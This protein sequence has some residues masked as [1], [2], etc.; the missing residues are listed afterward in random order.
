MGGL[1]KAAGAQPGQGR[2]CTVLMLHSGPV[3]ALLAQHSPALHGSVVEKK[4]LGPKPQALTGI[5][6]ESVF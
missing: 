4:R 2:Q 5:C 1:G 3:W 6:I